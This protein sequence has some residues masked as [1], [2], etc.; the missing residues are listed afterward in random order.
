MEELKDSKIKESGNVILSNNIPKTK[1]IIPKKNKYTIKQ[2]LD[3][4]KESNLTS[5]HAVSAK[6]GIDR[7]SVRDWIKQK[8]LLEKADTKENYRL[9]GAGRKS[10][11][12]EYEPQI[13]KWIEYHR[14]LGLALTMRSIIGY[15]LYLQ[16]EFGETKSY[17]ALKMWCSRFLKR[18]NLVFRRAGHIG[19]PLPKSVNTV[20]NG[21]LRDIIRARENMGI[22]D[23]DL[24]RIVN[25]DETP[26]FFDMPETITI[27][28]KGTKNVKIATFGNDKNRVS[29]ILS[30]AGDGTKLP[31][32]MIFKGEPGK[33]TEKKLKENPE[34]KNKKIY[35][36]CQQNSQAISD[37]IINWYNDIF[38]NYE[39]LKAKKNCLLVLDKAPTH[40]NKKVIDKFNSMQTQ[41]VY[42]PSGLTPYL[43]PLDIGINK[44]FKTRI[45][46]SYLNFQI[47]SIDK[48]NSLIMNKPNKVSKTDMISF[49]SNAWWDE[50]DGIKSNFIINSFKKSGITLKMDGSEDDL[51]KYPDESDENDFKIVDDDALEEGNK[52]S[53]SENDSDSPGK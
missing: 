47:S 30:I 16:P 14:K 48:N 15:L 52:E 4:I 17:D 31:P 33:I 43:Q 18:N 1:N 8:D 25:M 6:Y 37:I 38:K 45:K 44:P 26:I 46:N 39:L 49:V 9:L 7:N 34:V 13:L 2:K 28:V 5:I 19:Q 27:E 40:T 22:G 21:F 11:S 10:Y 41:Y 36:C 29:V 20:V 3:I 23:Q 53:D 50:K 24:G 51:F 42:I 35:I 32:L 12:F